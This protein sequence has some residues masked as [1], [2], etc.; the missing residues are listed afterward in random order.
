MDLVTMDLVEY[1]TEAAPEEH[2]IG[3][4]GQAVVQ[5]LVAELLHQLP[6]LQ[7]DT[8]M[9]GHGSQHLHVVLVVRATSPSRSAAIRTPDMPSRPRSGTPP[10]TTPGRQSS[11]ALCGRA[12]RP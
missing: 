6:V 2:S 7:G 8:G 12:L 3:Q 5:G 9:V 4:A 11:S 1:R 10:P